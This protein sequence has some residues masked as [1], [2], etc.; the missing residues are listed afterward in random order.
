MSDKPR[1]PVR[2]AVTVVT[3][4]AQTLA[5][6]R[7]MALALAL[8]LTLAVGMTGCARD[9]KDVSVV[10]EVRPRVGDIRKTISTTG[11]VQPQNRLEMKPPVAGRIDR[12]LVKEGQ[13][14]RAGEIVALMSSTER[15]ALLDAAKAKG[16]QELTYWQDT[17]KA[18]PLIA[19]IDG[20]V[21]VSV[22]QPGQAITQ[23]DP[24]IV[25][26]DRL[27]VQAQIDET[28]IGGVQEGQKAAITLDAYPSV[29][30]RATVSHIYH[31]STIVNNVT[32]Y[33]ADLLPQEIPAEFRSGMSA[34]AEIIEAVREGVLL[35]PAEALGREGRETTVL[36]GLGKNKKPETRV[37]Q[38]GLSD[39]TDT[40]IVSGLSE[41]DT[42]LIVS[43]KYTQVKSGSQGGGGNPFSPQQGRRRPS[44]GSGGSGGGGGGSGSG[45]GGGPGR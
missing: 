8:T 34:N 11:I 15:A 16:E 37:V 31:E 28:D 4:L 27:I 10:T 44:G 39:G 29:R 18:I 23:A 32:V 41:M 19:P 38:T 42:L 24:V 43:K 26:S 35:V 3:S 7:A 17:Y 5:V 36:V 12:I 9:A 2:S 30:V 13:K 6:T 22:M 14:V 40:E 20:T 33:K 25:L 1:T 45:S 21:I